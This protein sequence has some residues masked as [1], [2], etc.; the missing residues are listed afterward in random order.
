MRLDRWLWCARFYKTR[1]FA[2]DAIKGGHIK[3]DDQRCKPAKIVAVGDRL[4]I[5]KRTETWHVTVESLPGRRGPATEAQ[6]CF[7]E[8]EESIEQRLEQRTRRRTVAEQPLTAGRPDK[9]TRRLLRARR[10]GG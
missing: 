9:L 8:S 6:A 1:G 4:S 7:T 2:A 5:T 3:L 10:R